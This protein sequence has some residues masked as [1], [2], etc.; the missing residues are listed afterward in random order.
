MSK[1]TITAAGLLAALALA[2]CG[3]FEAHL[4]D[5]NALVASGART[6]DDFA[7]ERERGDNW[8]FGRNI[9]E[10]GGRGKAISSAIAAWERAWAID[11]TDEHIFERLTIAS[12]YLG[13]YY[14]EGDEE[15]DKVFL[16]GKAWAEKGLALDPE[17]RHGVDVEKKP[18]EEAV[19]AHAKPHQV[20]LMFWLCSNWGRAAENKSLATR[21]VT[22]PKLKALM[23]AVYRLG[24][25]YFYGGPQRFFGV[26]FTKA[27]G[28]KDPGGDSRK[29]FE[30][31]VEIGPEDLENK[32]LFAEYYAKFA[33]DRELF[34]KLLKEVLATPVDFGPPE[35]RL[36]NAEARKRA[37][38]LLEKADEIF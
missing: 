24:P 12:Y 22:A 30:R 21:A 26:Y 28:Q 2:G 11:P 14:T 8:W 15:K 19:V 23:E 31:A 29:Q 33:Q 3:S 35:L 13:N 34:E 10:E 6:Y 7:R 18:F 9:V 25:R 20:P 1:H 32:V 5:P 27:P 16:N 4:P 37:K 17:I 38:A 36:D